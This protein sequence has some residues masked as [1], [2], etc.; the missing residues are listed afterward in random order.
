[1]LEISRLIHGAQLYDEMHRANEQQERFRYPKTA[2]KWMKTL[3]K[4]YGLIGVRQYI[5][6]TDKHQ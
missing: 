5:L 2:V 3:K 6:K 4:V 1:M